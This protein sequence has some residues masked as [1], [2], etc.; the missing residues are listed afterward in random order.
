MS[1]TEYSANNSSYIFFEL[2]ENLNNYDGILLYSIFQ[3]PKNK[4]L[5][6]K[7][8]S[9]VLFIKK[10]LLFA[11]EDYVLKKTTDISKIEEII[12]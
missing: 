3:L 6:F 10:Y 11:V 5:R 4:N 2:L 1:A 8:Y 9:K 7:I 12:F